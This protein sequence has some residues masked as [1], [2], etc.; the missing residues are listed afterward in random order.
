MH[1]FHLPLQTMKCFTAISLHF[2]KIYIVQVDIRRGHA[3]KAQLL[4]VQ[5]NRIESPVEEGWP[6]AGGQVDTD[7]VDR[8]TRQ[9][10][11]YSHQRV[12]G[13]TV[14]R[15]CHQENTAQTVDH[16]EEERQ[17]NGPRHI[18]LFET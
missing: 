2:L 15:H 8:G 4:C 7:E 3:T 10:H 17:L 5:R 18:G 12:D 14:K 13:V 16:W 6:G 9:G 1:G 11:R